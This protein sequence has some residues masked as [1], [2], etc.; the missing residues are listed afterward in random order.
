MTTPEERDDIPE[1]ADQVLR[2]LRAALNREISAAIDRINSIPRVDYDKTEDLP[3]AT[4]RF[5][6]T[7][8]ESVTVSVYPKRRL[9]TERP[10]DIET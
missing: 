4:V 5:K 1:G 6:A 2:D 9:I 3:G 7:Q 10:Q 8:A